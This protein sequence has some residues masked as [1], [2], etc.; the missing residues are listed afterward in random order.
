MVE[1]LFAIGTELI[2]ALRKQY[3]TGVD[4]FLLLRILLIWPCSAASCARA[5]CNSAVC[6]SYVLCNMHAPNISA[7]EP[8][9]AR[10]GC[11][12]YLHGSVP[13]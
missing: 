7:V 1:C 10:R 5:R 9:N 2:E 3:V 13:H 6:L 4:P 11:Q 12:I 8:Y